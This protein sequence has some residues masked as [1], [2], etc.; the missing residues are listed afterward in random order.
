MFRAS[1][2]SYKNFKPLSASVL[3]PNSVSIKSLIPPL[4]LKIELVYSFE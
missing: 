2:L 1:C 3:D 4:V